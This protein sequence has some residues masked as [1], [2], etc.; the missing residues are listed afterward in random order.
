MSSSTAYAPRLSP[1][2]ELAAAH[3]E[4]MTLLHRAR[5]NLAVLV[6][7]A[8]PGHM[9]LAPVFDDG[10]EVIDFAWQEASPTATLALGCAGEGLVGHML[11]QVLVEGAMDVSVFAT[12]RTVFLQQRAET[13][14]INGQDGIAV[15]AMSPP[16]GSLTVEVTRVSAMDR[17]L[18]AQQAVRELA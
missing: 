17:A 18:S 14:R 16:P 2:P 6:E 1:Q 11:K 4:R 12:Y 9:V 3:A 5:W 8:E 10:G 13:L 7:L 15:H